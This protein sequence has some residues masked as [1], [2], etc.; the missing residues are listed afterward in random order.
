MKV[1]AAS[2]TTKVGLYLSAGLHDEMLATAQ[3]LST[4]KNPRG[5][6]RRIYERAFRELAEA[7]EAGVLVAF[8]AT[9]GVK[10]RISVRLSEALCVRV[11]DHTDD[12]SLKL[13][14][15][16]FAAV[17]RFLKSTRSVGAR[18]DGHTESVVANDQSAEVSSL[19]VR[20][21]GS[22]L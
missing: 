2:T 22:P 9:R 15:Y 13:T 1:V 19:S 18:P 8:P 6:V 20:R 4:R 17:N 5:D 21:R 10:V 12:L 14:D 11:R 7:I 3:R 16:A